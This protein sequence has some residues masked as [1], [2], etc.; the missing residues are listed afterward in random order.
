MTGNDRLSDLDRRRLVR[1]GDELQ[2]R[3]LEVH[4]SQ[5]VL[6]HLA[7]VSWSTI[8]NLEQGIRRPRRSAVERLSLALHMG[9]RL[10]HGLHG[11]HLSRAQLERVEAWELDDVFTKLLGTINGGRF[12]EDGRPFYAPADPGS[13]VEDI[14]TEDDYERERKVSEVIASRVHEWW[15]REARKKPTR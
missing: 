12:E 3:R 10:R 13:L 2:R 9:Y 1:F 4:V 7:E 14:L 15:E 8:R 6:G 11:E 5:S